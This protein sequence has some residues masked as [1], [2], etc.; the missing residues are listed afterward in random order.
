MLPLAEFAALISLMWMIG[1]WSLAGAAVLC[2]AFLAGE[3]VR[4]IRGDK[5]IIG[6]MV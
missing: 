3:V 6:K 1:I 4:D 2:I 5:T